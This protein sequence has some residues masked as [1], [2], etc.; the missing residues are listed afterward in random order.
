MLPVVTA[1]PIQVLG[2]ESDDISARKMFIRRAP[3]LGLKLKEDCRYNPDLL[4]CRNYCQ[5]VN[6]AALDL[7]VVDATAVY[8]TTKLEKRAGVKNILTTTSLLDI[9]AVD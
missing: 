9:K 1:C 7:F 5:N 8:N 2:G 3:P 4:G 6:S